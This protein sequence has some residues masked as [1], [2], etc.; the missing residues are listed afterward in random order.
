MESIKHALGSFA[1]SPRSPR[2][3]GS[4]VSPSFQTQAIPVPSKSTAWFVVV[5]LAWYLSSALSS[6]TSKALLSAPKSVK[7]IPEPTLDQTAS[8]VHDA[9]SIPL[10]HLPKP[11]APFPYPVTL[12][13]IQ[14]LFVAGFCLLCTS[15]RIL[16]SRRLSKAVAPTKETV[17]EVGQ[18]SV[19]AVVGHILSSV[20]ISRV[21][22]S[23]V[24]TI[25]VSRQQRRR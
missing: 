18:L 15:E 14:F 8:N 5:C 20:A 16:G 17:L 3:R 25:K 10:H 11:S 4:P 2:G 13:F 23:T 12:T 21:P 6:N 24:H 7:L 1:S 22:V 9:N 19:F